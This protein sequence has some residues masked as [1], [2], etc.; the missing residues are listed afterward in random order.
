MD[1]YMCEQ[2]ESFFGSLYHDGIEKTILILF[3]LVQK[4]TM[5]NTGNY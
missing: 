1:T 2:D 5:E 3:E 4:I